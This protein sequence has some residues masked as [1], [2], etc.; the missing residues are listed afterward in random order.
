M[1]KEQNS[2]EK[3]PTQKVPPV[4][5][6]GFRPIPAGDLKKK[7]GGTWLGILIIIVLIV[8]IMALP[9]KNTNESESEGEG[10]AGE[11]SEMIESTQVEAPA[12]VGEG[13]VKMSP[14]TVDGHSYSFKDIDWL[15]EGQGK[16][17]GGESLVMVRLQFVGFTRD[18]IAIDVLPYRLG[19]QQGVCQEILAPAGALVSAGTPLTFLQ[20]AS[21]ED[22]RQ[23]GVYQRGNLIESYLR[24]K[25]ADKGFNEMNKIQ[26]IDLAGIVK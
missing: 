6:E 13:V 26:T 9:E 12:V 8:L 10:L 16:T 19:I 22:V 5:S 18:G 21:G 25:L 24:Y 11:S 20:C 1:N 3:Q 2:W 14:V 7:G 4:Q 23:I 15:F 17:S